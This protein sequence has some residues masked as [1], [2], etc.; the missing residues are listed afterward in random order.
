MLKAVVGINWGDEGKGRI[1]DLMSEKADYVVRYQGGNNAGH[2]VL[3]R[4]ESSCLIFCHQE[5]FILM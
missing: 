3:H 5:Y 4:K 1:V 2:T